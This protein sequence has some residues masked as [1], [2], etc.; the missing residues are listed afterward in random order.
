MTRERFEQ[1]GKHLHQ[2]YEHRRRLN[3]GPDGEWAINESAQLVL[4]E[5][6]RE[7]EAHAP[8]SIRSGEWREYELIQEGQAEAA[9]S[10]WESSIR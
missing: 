5:L 3:Y 6:K 8:L 4:D 10:R 1:L 9:E 7:Q 2:Y